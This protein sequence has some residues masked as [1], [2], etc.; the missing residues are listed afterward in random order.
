MLRTPS[1]N[2]HLIK[3]RAP[4]PT[5]GPNEAELERQRLEEEALRSEAEEAMFKDMAVELPASNTAE[6]AVSLNCRV[7][8]FKTNPCYRHGVFRRVP[9][10]SIVQYQGNFQ[11]LVVRERWYRRSR[12]RERPAYRH[13]RRGRLAVM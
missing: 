7:E 12:H 3:Q 13:L 9:R 1:P 6:G 10:Y 5:P 4:E 2:M 11:R 8:Y